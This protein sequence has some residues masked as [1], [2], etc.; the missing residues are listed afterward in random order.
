MKKQ[1]AY[2]L[3]ETA[4]A[5]I[6]IT[7]IISMIG[8]GNYLYSQYQLRTVINENAYYKAA[9][10]TFISQ[11][12]QLPGDFNKASTIWPN[13]DATPANC[14]GNSNGIINRE[15]TFQYTDEALR[16]WQ[17]LYF[18]RLIDQQMSGY[19]NPIKQ[20]TIGINVPASKFPGAGWFIDDYAPTEL[21]RYYNVITLGAS[22]AGDINRNFILTATQ[23]QTIDQ[24]VDDGLPLSGKVKGSR[25]D[26]A[27]GGFWNGAAVGTGCALSATNT[28]NT[29]TAYQKVINCI[30]SFTI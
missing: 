10:T 15:Y 11:Y 28:Y 16:A 29:A 1:N 12:G 14:N 2:T 21:S 24:K 8:V 6:I 25:S 19:H 20:N 23:V 30:I 13:C 26:L 3:I 7:I 18:A 9:I 22:I 4:I 17:H 27:G 5:I